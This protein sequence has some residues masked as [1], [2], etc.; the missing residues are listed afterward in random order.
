[1]YQPVIAGSHL[2]YKATNPSYEDHIRPA[3]TQAHHSKPQRLLDLSF[4]ASG[5]PRCSFSIYLSN[6]NMSNAQWCYPVVPGQASSVSD[7]DVFSESA[8]S[9]WPPVGLDLADPH[10]G[11]GSAC[12]GNVG[13]PDLVPVRYSPNSR[14]KSI[15]DCKSLR[16]MVIIYNPYLLP[17]LVYHQVR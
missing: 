14:A 1:M 16:I 10:F 7:G 8:G 12:M 5:F 2:L 17:C 13:N 4:A 11:D 15:T 3:P 6:S 9:P